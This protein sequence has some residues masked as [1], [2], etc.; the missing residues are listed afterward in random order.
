MNIL[1]NEM[2]CLTCSMTALRGIKTR[3]KESNH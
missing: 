2:T 1:I 3:V